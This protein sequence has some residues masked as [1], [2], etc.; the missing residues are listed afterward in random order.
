VLLHELREC[1][2][3]GVVDVA[4]EGVE[5]GF[6]GEE[7]GAGAGERVETNAGVVGAA[8]AEAIGEERDFEAGGAGVEGGLINADG[9]FEA[10][11][12]KMFGGAGFDGG[13]DCGVAEGG[14][15]GFR[16]NDG[17]GK[18]RKKFGCGGAEFFGDLFG[19]EDVDAEAGGGLDRKSAATL[20]GVG[21]LHRFQ[22]DGL[23]VEAEKEESRMGGHRRRSRNGSRGVKPVAP[24][25]RF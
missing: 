7:V 3:E 4:E 15:G 14:K 23:E 1:A 22:E 10:A 2:E 11:E 19:E 13:A 17:G 24:W 25:V 12:E 18:E 21:R 16:K 6:A 9:C 5:D 8:G 20:E